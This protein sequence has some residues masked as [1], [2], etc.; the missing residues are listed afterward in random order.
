[1]SSP[2]AEALGGLV[3]QVYDYT[4][5]QL[6]LPSNSDM[7]RSN[8]C[9]QLTLNLYHALKR[10]GMVRREL[11]MTRSGLWHYVIAHTPIDST[12]SDA[13]VITDLT[14]WQYPES[15]RSGF[16]HAERQS[17][18]EALIAANAPEWLVSLRGLATIIEP[19][20]EKLTP[21]MK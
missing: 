6:Q 1:M 18:Q 9:D 4:K 10:G 2:Y 14:P 12:P 20:T 17:L 13:D 8:K 3:S 19:H 21:F 16:L 7:S 5:E 15:K 11:H